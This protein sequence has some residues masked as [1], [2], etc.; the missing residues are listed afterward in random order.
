VRSA[1]P[2]ALVPALA[3]TLLL[4]AGCAPGPGVR[5]L[6]LPPR[7]A[8]APGGSEIAREVRFLDLESREA[9]ICAEIERGNVPGWLRRLRPVEVTLEI[10]GRVH[11]AT[12]WVTPDYLAVGSDDDP[13][14]VPLSPQTAQRLADLM[15]GS[16]PTPRM[17]DAVWAAARVRLEPEP[18]PPSPEMTTVP[19]FEDHNRRVR[20][21][22]AR[23]RD[24][25]GS[26]VAG[27]KKDVVITASL[28]ANPG[29]VAIYGWHRT[30]G[31]V[32]QPLYAGHTDRWV[33]YSH[34]IRIV[35]REI[36]VDGKRLDLEEVLRDVT[37]ATLLSAE[38][39]IAE[40]RYGVRAAVR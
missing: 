35:H 4:A 15:D 2:R 9:R 1:V 17:V 8:G 12:F 11:R 37:L 31:R 5:V 26:L 34:G 40:P 30:D 3:C 29:K 18:I 21:Q 16:L 22:R 23:H 14:L 7:P 33:D 36:V 27:H 10:G 28:A 19:V 32:I 38:G 24:P 6:G 39:V 20:A 13:F 25:A